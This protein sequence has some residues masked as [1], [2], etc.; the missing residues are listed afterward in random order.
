MEP[1]S[2]DEAIT[3]LKW[4]DSYSRLGAV[5]QIKGCMIPDVWL[6]VLGKEWSGCDNIAQ[7]HPK[8]KRALGTTGPLLQMMSTEEQEVF[9]SLPDTVTVYRGC[10]SVNRKGCSWSLDREIATSFPTFSRYKVDDPMLIKG[11]VK[12][13]KIL[14]VKLCREEQ[15]VIS[16]NVKEVEVIP[17]NH[18]T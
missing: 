2:F 11:V 8:L 3:L 15:E 6:Q 1:M 9:N 13:N 18:S 5:M 7:Y 4:E 17:L 14:A 16:F 10:G 12:K